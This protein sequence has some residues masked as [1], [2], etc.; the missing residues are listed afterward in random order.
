MTDGM[1]YRFSTVVH[2]QESQEF[3]IVQYFG[4][5]L[6]TI[7]DVD[8]EEPIKVRFGGVTIPSNSLSD[9]PTA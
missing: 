1:H 5:C 8:T 2:W 4:T 3:V 6:G 7:E 9:T